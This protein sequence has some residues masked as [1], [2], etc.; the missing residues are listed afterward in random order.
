M[1]VY[2]RHPVTKNKVKN[3]NIICG[4]MILL[5]DYMCQ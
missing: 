5:F 3:Y 1:A 2:L 4:V